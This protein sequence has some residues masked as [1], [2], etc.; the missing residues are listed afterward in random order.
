MNY[1]RYDLQASED[2]AEILLAFLAELPFESFEMTEEGLAAFLSEKNNWPQVESRLERL[3]ENFPFEYRKSLLPGQ[4]WNAVWES[5]FQPIV[6]DDFCAVRAEFHEPVSGVEHEIVIQPKMAF[7]TGHHET[8]RMMMR[9]MRELDLSGASVFDFGCGTGIL[10]I[11]AAK[12]GASQIEAVDIEWEAYENTLENLTRNGISG[13]SVA[14][15]SI[16]SVASS[17]FDFILANINRNV[18]LNSLE[19]LSRLLRDSGRLLIS[20]FLDADAAVMREACQSAGFRICSELQEGTW[21]CW[22]LT[23]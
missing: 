8:T 16:E 21:L 12:L 20:G 15:G 5:N 17:Q 18:L 10:A 6:I 3:R 2:I 14:H 7:G 19:A 4:N 1:L 11:L 13:A 9:A 23:K 22:M